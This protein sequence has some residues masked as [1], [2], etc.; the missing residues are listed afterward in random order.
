MLYVG[1]DLHKKSITVCG[2]NRERQVLET[3]RLLCCEEHR[4]V[5]TFQ[6]FRETHQAVQVV[7]EATASYEWFLKLIEPVVDRVVLAHPKKLRVIAESTRKSDKLDAKILAEFLALDMIPEAYRPTP[8]Q[9]EHRALV[10]HRQR[11][12]KQIT[13]TKNSI[14]RLL[15]HYNADIENLFTRKG[16]AYLETRDM[17]RADRFAMNQ[18]LVQLDQFNKQLLEA[19]RELAAFAKEGSEREA[20]NR[21]ILKSIGGVGVVTTDVV[22]SELGDMQ[23]FSN[24]KK[25]VAYAG[26]APGQRESAGK[27]KDL[28]IEK[29]GSRLLRATLVEAAWQLVRRSPKYHSI[30]NRLWERTGQKKKAIVAIARRLLT[31]MYSL[32]KSR[33]RFRNGLDL[34]IPTKPKRKRASTKTK[35]A[36]T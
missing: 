3:R 15:S 11:I 36:T 18:S 27:R 24:A 32:L 9:R 30:F 19:D 33:Q 13:A 2:V 6:T 4:I 35:A 10:R 26:L 20:E 12:R 16:R 7:V 34:A 25:V 28:H 1:V 5:E 17:S 23:R 21:E 29:C 14:R 8:R 22:V 31:L